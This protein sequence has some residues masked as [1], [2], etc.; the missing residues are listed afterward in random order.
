MHRYL[1]RHHPCPDQKN[2]GSSDAACTIE[3]DDGIHI[4]CFSCNTRFEVDDNDY[5]TKPRTK[6]TDIDFEEVERISTKYR[7]LSTQTL[8][9]I[10]ITK[11]SGKN[12]IVYPY[13]SYDKSEDQQKIRL[14]KTPDGKKKFKWVGNAEKA[15]LFGHHLF[16][17]GGKRITV[18]TGENDMAA[19]IEMMGW[20]PTVSL[21][22]GDGSV[23]SLTEEDYEYLDSFGEIIVCFDNDSSGKEAMEKF[24]NIFPAKSKIVELPKGFKDAHDMLEAG[25]LKSF[26]KCWW[27]AQEYRPS[28]IVFPSDIK[29]EVINPK[30]LPVVPYPWEGLNSRIFGMHFPELILITAQT[31]SGKSIVCGDIT[32]HLVETT[33]HRVADISIESTPGERARTLLS[34]YMKKPLHLGLIDDE[35]KIPIEEQSTKFDEFFKDDR[36]VLY[37]KFGSDNSAEILGKI[38]YFVEVLGCKFVIFDHLNYATSYHEE[39]ERKALDKLSNQLAR[40]AVEKNFCLILVAHENDEGRVF[41]SRNATKVCFTH[42]QIIR[43]KEAKSDEAKNISEIKCKLNRRYGRDGFSVWLR[44]NE[45]TYSFN[46]ID[47]EIAQSILENNEEDI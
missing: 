8:E 29:N 3:D 32:R 23:K 21:K 43:D 12:Q 30:K 45:K 31:K 41:G 5:S 13:C 44:F 22:N 9:K 47:E 19:V 39:D 2:C 6:S 42:L 27:N 7:S 34:L 10:G 4:F 33:G 24:V 46:E 38:D 14:G 25:E 36:I 20:F 37:D 28:N 15:G 26:E 17:K 40:K 35:Y 16:P 11:V 1:E 18:T